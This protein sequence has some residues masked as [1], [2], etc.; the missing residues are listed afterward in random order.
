MKEVKLIATVIDLILLSMRDLR[1]T[2]K[3]RAISGILILVI[4]ISM[5]INYHI[6]GTAFINS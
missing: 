6:N 4:L 3:K 2:M 5:L 1:Q